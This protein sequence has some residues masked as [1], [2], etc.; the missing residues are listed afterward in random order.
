MSSVPMPGFGKAQMAAFFEDIFGGQVWFIPA[1]V[2]SEIEL[3]GL[4]EE[5]A[6]HPLARDAEMFY[7]YEIADSNTVNRAGANGAG[8]E[9]P[10]D[11]SRRRRR[12]DPDLAREMGVPPRLG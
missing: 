12:D 10:R 3:L 4:P 1:S 9:H 11:T 2:G 8:G 7:T 5:A 6:L